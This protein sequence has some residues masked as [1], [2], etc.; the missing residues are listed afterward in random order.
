MSDD[1]AA[2]LSVARFQRYLRW[3]DGDRARA[4]DLYALNTR[5]SEALYT[6]LQTLEVTFRNR[7]HAV[8]SEEVHER[9]FDQDGFLKIRRQ[10]CQVEKARAELRRGGKKPTPE[11]IVAVLSFGFWIS[12]LSPD[13]EDLWQG[14]LRRIASR[15]NRVGLRRKEL[16][17]PLNRIRDLRNRCAHHEPVIHWNLPKHYAGILI[18]VRWLAPPAAVWCERHSRF[19]MVFPT[20]RI[21]LSTSQQDAERAER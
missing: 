4:L 12:M 10:P 9:W 5:V 20:E 15:E 1:F 6:P 18:V 11:R 13:Y 3:A 8:L 16:S 19:P 2:T 21:A 17:S 7:M 14:S